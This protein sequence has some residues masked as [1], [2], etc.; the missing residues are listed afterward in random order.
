VQGTPVKAMVMARDPKVFGQIP[1][2]RKREVVAEMARVTENKVFKMV[3]GV[4]EYRIGPLDVLTIDSRVG[5]KLTTTEV[6]V[7][8]RGMISYSFLDDVSV[9]DL[10]PSEVDKLLTAKLSKYVRNPRI[11]VRVS[12]FES[13]T[14]LISGEFV[15]LRSRDIGQARSGRFFLTG[16][17]SLMDLIAMAGGYTIDADIKNVRLIRQGRKFPINLYNIIERGDQTQ[18]VIIDAGDIV[19]IPESPLGQRVYVLGAVANQGVY[20]LQDARDL[21]TALSL[22]G[23]FTGEAKEENTL[24]VRGYDAPGAKPLVMMADLDALL[25]KADVSQNIP[26]QDG[27]LV[28]VPRMLIADINRWIENATPM[29]ELVRWPAETYREYTLRPLIKNQ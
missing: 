18:N 13:K 7:N 8:S 15:S 17:T 16:K 5:E 9:D 24:I 12:K 29:L 3:A 10:T 1:S 25:N 20:R 4:P 26:L 11:D 6:P 19:D 14:A 27:D 21:L 22:A 28:Y 23:N 2:Q